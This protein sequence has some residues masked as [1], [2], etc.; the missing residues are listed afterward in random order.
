MQ[1]S[2]LDVEFTPSRSLYVT[3]SINFSDPTRPPVTGNT[4]LVL[5]PK[6][7]ATRRTITVGLVP[8]AIAFTP[9]GRTAYVVNNYG[10]SVSI[11]STAGGKTT[12]TVPVRLAPN[13][14]AVT[15]NGK[16]AFVTET[17]LGGQDGNT[18]AVI[19]KVHF[20]S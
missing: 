3:S 12:A 1:L 16:A 10:N 11:V 14:V 9:N 7:L 13:G 5:D 20:H 6:T 19:G 4:V 2:A 17:G 8:I 15:N 18:V